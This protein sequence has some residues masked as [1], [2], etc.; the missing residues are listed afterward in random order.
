MFEDVVHSGHFR[1]AT[2]TAFVWGPCRALS[3]DRRGQN[4]KLDTHALLAAAILIDELTRACASLG[5]PVGFP[6]LF[7]R[8]HRLASQSG[9]RGDLSLEGERLGCRRPVLQ[10]IPIALGGTASGPMHPTDASQKCHGPQLLH[11]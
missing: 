6:C 10:G 9:E 11:K 5:K 3:L 7:D 8:G 2:P 4:A 1:V